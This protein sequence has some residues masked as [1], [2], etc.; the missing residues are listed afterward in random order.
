MCLAAGMDDYLAKP[1][2]F[3]SPS[4]TFQRWL[5]A[6]GGAPPACPARPGSTP[7]APSIRAIC[8]APSAE[9]GQDH[10]AVLGSYLTTATRDIEALAVL[11]D[12]FDPSGRSAACTTSKRQRLDRGRAFAARCRKAEQAARA[13]AWDAVR[14]PCCRP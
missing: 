14:A 3:E 2:T 13:D 9:G 11:D 6:V 5:P 8:P 10:P 12:D 1:V 4:A 7:V